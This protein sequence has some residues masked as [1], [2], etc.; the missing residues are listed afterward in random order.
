MTH[1]VCLQFKKKAKN[2]QMLENNSFIYQVIYINL[3]SIQTNNP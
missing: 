2:V 1:G 3:F